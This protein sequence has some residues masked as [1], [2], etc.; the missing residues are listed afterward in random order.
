MF[1][2]GTAMFRA[3]KYLRGEE[4]DIFL[5]HVHLDHV[6]GLTYLMNVLREHPLRCVRVHAPPDKLAAVDAHLFSADLF[7]APPSYEKCPLAHGGEVEV[8]GGGRV[9][10]FPLTHNGG[11]LGFR[12]DFPNRSLAYVTDTWADPDAPYVEKIRGVDLLIHECYFPDENAAWAKTTGHGHASAVARVA[13]KAVAARLV[14]VHTDPFRSDDDPVGL[15]AARA[16]FAKTDL[17]EDYM[18]IEF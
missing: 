17:G 11:S 2:A 18:E 8:A 1:D 14:L 9:T 13:K 5:S 16:I 15:P 10:H 4:L 6:V 3:G 7:P 12:L